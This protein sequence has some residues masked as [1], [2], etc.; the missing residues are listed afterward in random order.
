[1]TP[2]DRLR[3]DVHDLA[4]SYTEG[5]YSGPGLLVQLSDAHTRVL[6]AAQQGGRRTVPGSRPPTQL[7]HTDLIR[8]IQC[9]AISW[10]YAFGG[11]HIRQPLKALRWLPDAAAAAGEGDLRLKGR[12]GLVST[13]SSW[14]GS[15]R[16]LLGFTEPAHHY[17]QA[18]CPDCYEA[19]HIHG[20]PGNSTAWCQLCGARISALG[21]AALLADEQDSA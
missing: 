10:A 8:V 1:M 12:H 14:V 5:A 7:D 19:G 4:D 2:I 16:H 6:R 11:I 20:R 13:V 9:G 18:S 3:N 15:C 17:P 21:Y